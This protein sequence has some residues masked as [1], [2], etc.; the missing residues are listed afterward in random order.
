MKLSGFFDGFGCIYILIHK[1]LFKLYDSK[2]MY[3]SNDWLCNNE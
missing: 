2:L 3:N 1:Y